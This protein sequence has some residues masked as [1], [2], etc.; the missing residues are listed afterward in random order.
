MDRRRFVK[1]CSVGAGLMAGGAMLLAD[2]AYARDYR[3]VR[4]LDETAHPLRLAD[5]S[6]GAQYVFH[7]PFAATPCFLLDLGRPVPGRNGLRTEAGRAYDWP[8]G[9]GPAASVVAYS[10][11]CAH[12]MA[13]P[14]RTVS[15][16]AYR[17]SRGDDDPE[18]GVISCCAENSVYDPLAGGAVLSGPAPQPLAAIVLEHDAGRDELYA[19]GTVG[20]EQFQRFFSEF[21]ARLSLEYPNGNADEPLAGDVVAYRLENFSANVLTC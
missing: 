6:V 14:T 2:H 10:A 1:T 16:I 19:V 5:L 17:P 4:L 18:A 13:H 7:Y 15:Y 20:G 9:V 12:K 11:I 3:R 8:G 21:A